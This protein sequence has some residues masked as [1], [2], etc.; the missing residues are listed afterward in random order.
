MIR[1]GRSRWRVRPNIV[2]HRNPWFGWSTFDWANCPLFVK[3]PKGFLHG[4]V[5]GCVHFLL[6]FGN[7]KRRWK[8]VTY[9]HK[10]AHQ[11]VHMGRGFEIKC[12]HRSMSYTRRSAEIDYTEWWSTT[13]GLIP[14]GLHDSRICS[15]V[16]DHLGGP[17][18]LWV[19]PWPGRWA[20]TSGRLPLVGEGAAWPRPRLA[21][22]C[23]GTKCAIRL[24]AA[25]K[26]A[27]S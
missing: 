16:L 26:G 23:F 10:G 5:L 17:V 25:S 14:I 7:S 22:N 1:Q 19:I 3:E 9:K 11:W 18:E 15:T 4:S 12:T 21:S 27:G 24:D 6:H 8:W 20:L 13:I 2:K